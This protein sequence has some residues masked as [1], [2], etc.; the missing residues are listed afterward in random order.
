MGASLNLESKRMVSRRVKCSF[1]NVNLVKGREGNLH[2]RGC[3]IKM[4]AF[5]RKFS[6]KILDMRWRLVAIKHSLVECN[7]SCS[8]DDTSSRVNVVGMVWG[9]FV[10]KKM[11]GWE[12]TSTLALHLFMGNAKMQHPKMCKREIFLCSPVQIVTAAAS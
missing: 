5:Q 8:L 6:S 11:P 12:W 2:V 1:H 10:A 4:N 3:I 9:L 7:M